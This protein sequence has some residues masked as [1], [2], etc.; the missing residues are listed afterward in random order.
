MHAE[1]TAGL[2]YPT[3]ESPLLA[4]PTDEQMTWLERSRFALD[5]LFLDPW[6]TSLWTLQEAFLCPQ[7][8]LIPREA[9]ASVHTLANLCEWCDILQKA[10]NNPTITGQSYWEKNESSTSEMVRLRRKYL[11]E[12]GTMITH[13]SLAALATR[14]PI[15]L[16]GAACY[17]KT[18]NDMDRVYAIEQVFDLRLGTSA[19]GAAER[20]VHP[21]AL[22][23][24]LGTS[25]LEIYPVLSQMHVFIEPVEL[26][27]G[28][29]IN[30][31]SRIPGLSL[32]TNLAAIRYTP[33]CSLTTARAGGM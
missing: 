3:I 26:G 4:Q 19:L 28:W 15:A 1:A 17:R 27:R 25:I 33:T 16:Y 14:N 29:R 5:K 8:C 13:R 21:L 7:A 12:V 9:T 22:Q 32:N 20:I 31:A 24:E 30:G 11:V 23:N 18:R 2:E 10:C 6:F